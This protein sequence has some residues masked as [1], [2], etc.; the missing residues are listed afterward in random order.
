MTGIAAPVVLDVPVPGGD[1]IPVLRRTIEQASSYK[2]RA[3][4]IRLQQGDYHIYRTSSSPCLYYIS[5]TASAEENPDPTKHIGIWLKDMKNITVDGG[6]ARFVTHGEMTP[7]VIDG[8]ENVTLKNFSL[9]AADPS[10]PEMTVVST[11]ANSITARVTAGSSYE[12][13]DGKFY[14]KGEG[15]RFGGGIAQVFYPQTNVTNRCESP[16]AGVTKAIELDE[17]LVRFNYDRAPGFKTGE[18]YQMR[19]S[20]RTEACGFIHQ[21]KDVKLEN[22]KFHFLGN[23][24]IVGQ[25]SENL[26]YEKLYCAP[27]WG[28]GRTCAGFADFVQMSGCK[29]K[30]RILDSYFE[31]AHDDPI[32]IHGTHLKV[33]EYVSDRQVKVRFMHGQSYGFE[34]FYKGDEV[35]FV[36]AHSRRCLQPARVKAVERIDDYEILLT[37]DRAVNDNVKTAENVSVENVTWT[38]EVEIRNNYFSRI[39]TRGILVTTRRK[40]VIED[41]VFYRI[42]MSGVLVSDDARGWY[43]SG[44]VRDVTI[45]RNLF[46]EC[47]SP[48]I[49]MMPENDRYE[50]AVHRNVRI[51]ANRFVIRQGSEA[52]SA[53]A[54][55][56]LIIRDNYIS[57]AGDGSVSPDAFFRTEDCKDVTIS[58][59]RCG[60]SLR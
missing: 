42:P 11:D 57:V 5:N 24:G 12:I 54:T 2:G 9:V 43:E 29:G 26:T 32:N 52:V 10:V 56:G 51:E 60:R 39:P 1:A 45:R 3:V 40:V 35:E 20:F 8:C 28:S 36:D 14:W 4:L 37:L 50:G 59:N 17:G 34:A 33:M 30:I 53:R 49:A 21:S 58:G 6:G 41:N 31:G 22:I 46:M 44:P 25:Y 7:F 19:H 47:G 27:E 16:L 15:W 48:V 18:V 38:P 13:E 55:D 23:F